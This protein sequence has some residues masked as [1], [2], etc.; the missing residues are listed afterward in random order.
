MGLNKY[1]LY[2]EENS[3]F[4]PVERNPLDRFIYSACLWIIGGVLLCGLGTAVFSSFTGTPTAVALK[5]ENQMLRQQLKQTKQ[6]IQKF[7]NRLQALAQRDNQLYRA[8]LGLKPI[9]QDER[10]AGM[11][12]AEI[13]SKFETFDRETAEILKWTAKHLEQLQYK[14]NIQQNSYQR[15][16]RAY[17]KNQ[18]KFRHI[19]AIKPANGIITSG[20]GMRYHPI[21]GYRTMHEGI[22]IGANMG[23]P[24]Y[25]TAKGV[26]EYARRMGT[27]GNLVII[28]HGYGYKTYYAHLSAFAKNI[29]PGTVVKRGQVIGFVGSTGRSTGAH[30]HY[31]VHKNGETVNPMRYIFQGVTPSEY[32]EMKRRAEQSTKSMD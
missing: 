19:P 28:D 24:V 2:D 14:I 25:A 1:F 9:S 12:G 13:Y 23:D 21:L 22:D 11:G 3:N 5:A 27:Y 20:Y 32:M 8:I 26:V 29:E 10:T 16:K 15:I 18:K 30:L 6:T 4:I 31:E 7:N 17:K